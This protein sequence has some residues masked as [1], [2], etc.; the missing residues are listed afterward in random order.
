MKYII[1]HHELY[2]E[3][4]YHINV[5]YDL[6]SKISGMRQIGNVLQVEL[7]VVYLV[8]VLSW[9]P[10]EVVAAKV[11]SVWQWAT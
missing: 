3:I 10:A 4:L 11:A 5:K 8:Y 1:C 9:C 6:F 2:H 7:V